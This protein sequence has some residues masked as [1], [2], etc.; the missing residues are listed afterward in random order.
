MVMKFGVVSDIAV[1]LQ[2]EV[3]ATTAQKVTEFATVGDVSEQVRDLVTRLLFERI[4]LD[5]VTKLGY[6]DLLRQIEGGVA[7]IATE[8][9]IQINS[10]EQK[11][12][13]R[14]IADDMVGVGPLEPLLADESVTDILVNGFDK[15]FVERKGKLILTTERFRNDTHIR[16]VAQRIARSIGR[17]I[18]ETSPMVDARLPDG[19]RVNI[20]FPPL[21]VDGVM[22]SIRRFAKREITLETMVRQGNL[23]DRMARFLAIACRARLNILVSGGTGSGK[24]TMMNAMSRNIDPTERIVTIEDSCELR[25]QQPHIVRLETRQSSVEGGKEISQRDLVK[26]ALR[27]RPDRIIIG[28][29]REG[30]AF[31]MLQAMNTGHEGSMSTLHANNPRDALMRLENMVLMSGFELPMKAIRNNIA[32]AVDMIVQVER[33][34]DGVRRITRIT[35]V[36]GMEGEI[37]STQDIFA[38][39]TGP[40]GDANTVSGSYKALNFRPRCVDKV[41]RFGLED[42]LT[43]VFRGIKNA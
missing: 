39:D 2:P 27:M 43:A 29:V 26:N 24:T 34:R 8:R 40:G 32:S 11:L 20:V 25:L 33:M 15:I 22:I 5:L 10:K 9:R 1:P 13:A 18:D 3:V 17:R 31:D 21:S 14:R 16:A 36:T 37:L 23:D 35:E 42:Q 4:N 28:E 41:R 7:D 19:S 38:W 12:L 30:E 6:D